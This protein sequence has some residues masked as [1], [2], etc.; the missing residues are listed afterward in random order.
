MQ[1]L[2]PH[3]KHWLGSLS[4]RYPFSLLNFTKVVML[5]CDFSLLVYLF[6]YGFIL[7]SISVY[8][9]SSFVGLSYIFGCCI[10]CL[11]FLY[12]CFVSWP[13]TWKLHVW[14]GIKSF[15]CISTYLPCF[16]GLYRLPL[17]LT[18]NI[19]LCTLPSWALQKRVVVLPWNILY[20]ALPD[21]RKM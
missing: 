12:N 9:C 18:Q 10:I 20:S 11:S 1:N 19:D 7:S 16:P 21:P 13:R 4:Y 15:T 8:I 14:C 6:L 17:G 2:P 5:L 3:P